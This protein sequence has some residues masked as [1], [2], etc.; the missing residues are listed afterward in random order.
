ASLIRDIVDGINATFRELNSKGYIVDGECWFDEASNDK[1]SLKAGKLYIA[2]DYTP[3][4]TLE[5]LSLRQRI[6]DKYLVNLAESV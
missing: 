6:T 2:Y 3:V 4:P 5:C 1:E